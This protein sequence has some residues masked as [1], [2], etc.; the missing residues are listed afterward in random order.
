MQAKGIKVVALIS[1]EHSDKSQ[2]KRIDGRKLGDFADIVL[3]TGAPPGDAMVKV[4]GLETPVSPGSTLGG[5]AVVNC[6][7]AEVANILTKEGRPPFVLTAPVLIGPE[8]S[9][10]LFEKAYDE[11]GRLISGLYKREETE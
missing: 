7:K 6:I 3:D 4:P 10:T 1:K 8:R 11:H 9:A 5:V 2:S